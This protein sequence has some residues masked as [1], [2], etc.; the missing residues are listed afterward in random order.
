MARDAEIARARGERYRPQWQ[1]RT[2]GGLT[3]QVE[4]DRI[5]QRWRVTPGGYEARTLRRALSFATGAPEDS[6]WLQEICAELD[7]L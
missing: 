5:Q 3:L 1:I 2:P 7:P 6:A 4:H